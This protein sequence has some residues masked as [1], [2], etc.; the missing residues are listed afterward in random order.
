M[1][2][3]RTW[4]SKAVHMMHYRMHRRVP[5]VRWATAA[6]LQRGVPEG[7]WAPLHAALVERVAEHYCAAS[8]GDALFGAVLA[9]LLDE[10][11]TEAAVRFIYVVLG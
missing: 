11:P 7:P 10:G 9:L 1:V 2:S 6:L 8:Y 4:S 3:S 5:L